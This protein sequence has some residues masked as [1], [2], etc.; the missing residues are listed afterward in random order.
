MAAD[1]IKEDPTEIFNQDIVMF[2]NKINR[3]IKEAYHS[4]SNAVSGMHVH[5]ITRMRSYVLACRRYLAWV[6]AQ[7][8]L[9]LPETHPRRS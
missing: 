5:D 3:Y 8:L 7:P 2:Y 4:Q 9:D 6:A 1:F